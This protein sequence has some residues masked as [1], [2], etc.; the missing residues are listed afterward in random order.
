MRVLVGVAAAAV[1][2]L[3]MREAFETIILPRRVHKEFRF[4]VL[5]FRAVWLLWAAAGRIGGKRRE[6][7][8]GVFGPASLLV[9]LGL[10]AGMLIVGFAALHWATG[11]QVDAKNATPD[12]TTLLYASGTT[13]FT[14]GIGDVTPNDNAGR[15]IT[16]VESGLGFAFLGLVITYV[17]ILY[18]GFSKRE[19]QIAL[20]DARAGSPPCGAELLRRIGA[21]GRD[22]HRF[23]V[24]DPVLAAWEQWCVELLEIQLSY[25]SLIF[26]R[27]QQDNQSWIGTLTAIHDTCA[28]LIADADG[29]ATWQAR[30]TFGAARHAAVDMAQYLAVLPDSAGMGRLAA[31]DHDRIRALLAESGVPLHTDEDTEARLTALRALYEPYMHGLAQYL[32]FDLPAWL[33]DARARDNWRTT[34]MGDLSHPRGESL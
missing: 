7:W 16:V 24:L 11:G 21:N 13:F 17:P 3:I 5:F 23:A 6:G 15:V 31:G 28:L 33:P 18:Q 20:L 27:S 32:V 12:F 2:L 4:T 22:S 10:W 1:I 14:L 26:F 29:I 30:V 19:T 34:S 25:P 9:L 8:L